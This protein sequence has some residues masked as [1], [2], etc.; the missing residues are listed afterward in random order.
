MKVILKQT[1]VKKAILI[2]LL[3]FV[4]ENLLAEDIQTFS[5]KKKEIMELSYKKMLMDIGLLESNIQQCKE[6]TSNNVL[7]PAL[8][9][10][11]E[12]SLEEWKLALRYFGTK[13][14]RACEG[15]ILWGNVIT[16]LNRMKLV[17][18]QYARNSEIENRYQQGEY[19]CVFWEREFELEVKYL[20]IDTNTQRQLEKVSE[21]HRPFN[22]QKT[23]SGIESWLH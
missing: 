2:L 21:L 15:E 7:S 17:E 8:F 22:V 4:S 12:L 18:K 1:T 10:T 23:V 13:A 14:S 11:I 16:A 6:I 9:N 20:H 19:C 3:L 5:V